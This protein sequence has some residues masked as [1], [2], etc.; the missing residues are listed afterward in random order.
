LEW[1]QLYETTCRQGEAKAGDFNLVG[2]NSSVH[3]VNCHHTRMTELAHLA[4]IAHILKPYLRRKSAPA[5]GL[6]IADTGR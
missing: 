1:Q 5:E 3:E 2:W 6:I 4:A